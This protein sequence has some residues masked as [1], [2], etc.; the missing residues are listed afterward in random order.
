VIGGSAVAGLWATGEL[1]GS[2]SLFAAMIGGGLG[3]VLSVLSRMSS[4]KLQI[5]HD[6]GPSY[7]GWLGGIRPLLGAAFAVALY[8][9]IRGEVV[10]IEVKT[11]TSDIAFYFAI[12]F[13]AGFSERWVKDVLHVAEQDLTP[14]P[15]PRQTGDQQS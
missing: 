9:A 10:P 4:G 11:G 2:R 15:Q 6:V 12:G 7:I 14:A 5:H 1:P 8:Y 3:A 13:L